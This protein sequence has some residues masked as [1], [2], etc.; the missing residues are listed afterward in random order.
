MLYFSAD[1]KQIDVE[2][3][4]TRYDAYHMAN[5]QFTID[6]P[7]EGH[8]FD[9][10]VI[11]EKY[12]KE[13]ANCQH[14]NIYYKS[15]VCGFFTTAADTF[16]D[17][18]VGD[19]VFD[20]T[21]IDEKYFV[22]EANCEHG[23]TYKK[24]CLCGLAGED[25]FEYGTG[26]HDYE[27]QST[28]APNWSEKINGYEVWV[29][30]SDSSHVENRPISWETLSATVIIAN[31]NVNGEKNVVVELGSTVTIVAD[32]IEGKRFVKWMMNGSVVG[33]D[34]EYTL[35]VNSKL[36]SITAYFVDDTPAVEPENPPADNP[37]NDNGSTQSGCQMSVNTI[38]CGFGICFVSALMCAVI[39]KKRNSKKI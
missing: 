21:V 26:S 28:V 32:T 17:G 37:N 39:V 27:Y 29:C 19:H 7:C 13:S 16:D 25:T 23:V 18:L 11:D 15:C 34:N 35:T 22:A 8:V 2:T 33:T 5:N 30:K 36:I 1:G 38:D 4:S 20:Q 14:G 3:Y 10:M 12:L 24:S 9:Q 31:G 6:M